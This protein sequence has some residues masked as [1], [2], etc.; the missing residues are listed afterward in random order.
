MEQL[1]NQKRAEKLP[2]YMGQSWDDLMQNHT[3]KWDHVYKGTIELN[4]VF[5][6]LQGLIERKNN[7]FWHAKYLVEYIGEN[8]VQFGLRIRLFP[9]FKNPSPTFK[10][11]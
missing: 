9:H 4:E 2:Q 10:S 5:F 8:I 11:K 1:A 6:S 7:L 3:S